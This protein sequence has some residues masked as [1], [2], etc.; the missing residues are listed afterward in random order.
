MDLEDMLSE[1]SETYN[2]TISL[3]L[4]PRVVKFIGTEVLIVIVRGWGEGEMGSWCLMGSDSFGEDEKVLD[5]DGG[6][7]CTIIGMY[8][9]F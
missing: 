9:S 8:F 6:D 1:I 3:A 5:M 7:G 2:G 4:D